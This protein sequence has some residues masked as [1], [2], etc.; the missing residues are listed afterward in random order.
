MSE[1]FWCNGCSCWWTKEQ[2]YLQNH[3]LDLK[4]TEKESSLVFRAVQSWCF[5]F[6]VR[7]ALRI[8][9]TL[10]HNEPILTKKTKNQT[11]KYMNLCKWKSCSCPMAT[12]W[13]LCLNRSHLYDRFGMNEEQG[14]AKSHRSS[15][16]Y[17]FFLNTPELMKDA[18]SN[19]LSYLVQSAFS[20]S[21]L[22]FL[23]ASAN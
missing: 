10:C 22:T 7:Q 14:F 21:P 20:T 12:Q 6:M 16:T 2:F 1:G 3:L 18:T 9:L 15:L 17:S 8:W 13:P 19:F 23:E 5:F 11:F 4:F